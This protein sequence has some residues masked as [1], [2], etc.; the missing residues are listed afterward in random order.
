MTTQV[1]ITAGHR[2]VAVTIEE[3]FTENKPVRTNPVT[4]TPEGGATA[5]PILVRTEHATE[6]VTTVRYLTINI[7]PQGHYETVVTDSR[8]I[9]GIREYDQDVVRVT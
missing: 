5:E 2:P 7:E 1:K 4:V 8:W 9:T 6:Q 3:R